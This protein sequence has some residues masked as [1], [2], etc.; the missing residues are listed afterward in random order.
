MTTLLL[1]ISVCFLA[2]TAQLP[3]ENATIYRIIFNDDDSELYGAIEESEMQ[4]KVYYDT[5]WAPQ[6]PETIPKRKVRFEPLT[7]ALRK[8]RQKEEAA[9]QGYELVKNDF[10]ESWVPRA[11]IELA[12]RARTMVWKQQ[13]EEEALAKAAPVPPSITVSNAAPPT[14]PSPVRQYAPHAVIATVGLLLSFLI[15][16]MTLQ[17]D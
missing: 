12:D 14:T 4:I 16:K 15:L 8:S 1:A 6:A 13:E 9:K 17:S 5:P 2:Q 11:E 10:G 3:P 7:S